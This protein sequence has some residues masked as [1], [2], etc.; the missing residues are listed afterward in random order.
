MARIDRRRIDPNAPAVKDQKSAGGKTESVSINQKP[1]PKLPHERDET[2][3][4]AAQPNERMEK[5][6]DDVARGVQDTD[7]GPVTDDT[8][9]KLRK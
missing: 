3:D 1:A 4:T 2:G 8:Y 5:A 6:H 9:H 7:R